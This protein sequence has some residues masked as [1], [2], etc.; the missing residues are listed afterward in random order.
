[1][2]KKLTNAVL[3]SLAAVGAF[4]LL[5]SLAGVV[6][7]GNLD[8]PGTPGPTMQTLDEL[9]PSWFKEISGA[10]RFDDTRAQAEGY[11][12]DRETGLVWEQA[13]DPTLRTWYQA[14]S[15]CYARTVAGEIGQSLGW[16][17]AT[18]Q[19]LGTLV[20]PMAGGAPYL[21]AGH[22]F[23]VSLGDIFWAAT[24][25]PASGVSNEAFAWD[26]D[27]GDIITFTLDKSLTAK[28]WCVRSPSGFDIDDD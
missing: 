12:L 17:L 10:A 16:R 15:N 13:P 25:S 7:G 19:E 28:A 26:T 1:M 20:E 9:P 4:W 8:P 11:V 6:Q 18:I 5:T 21:P 3:L 27:F 22:P 2:L 24:T 14:V 23:T